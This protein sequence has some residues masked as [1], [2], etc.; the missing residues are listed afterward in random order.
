MFTKK[1][2]HNLKNLFVP[3]TLVI[4]CVAVTL[5]LDSPVSAQ[6]GPG[7]SGN[8][9]IS[10]PYVIANEGDLETMAAFYK[11]GSGSVTVYYYSLSN[12]ITLTSENFTPIGVSGGTGVPFNGHFNGNGHVITGLKIS[13]DIFYCG[14][15]GCTSDATIANLGLQNVNISDTNTSSGV[16]GLIGGEF[17]NIGG[18]SISNCWVSGTVTGNAVVGGLIGDYDT[19]GSISDCYSTA[20]VTGNATSRYMGGLIGSVRYGS[21]SNCFASGPVTGNNHVGGLVGG[22]EDLNLSYCYARG[23]FR[24]LA[25]VSI[26]RRSF[27]VWYL[28]LCKYNSILLRYR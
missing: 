28:R 1:W 26:R 25:P 12:D 7:L 15:F 16:G 9:T 6:T 19:D 18:S 23:R 24:E 27:R 4:V 3:I 13:G 11:G 22:S 20:S 5:P 8:G 17:E 10:N 21:L 2:W 14:F